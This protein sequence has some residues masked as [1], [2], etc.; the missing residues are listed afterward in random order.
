MSHTVKQTTVDLPK[1]RGQRLKKVRNM[2]NMSRLEMCEQHDFNV[3]T[4]KG[5]EIGRHGGLTENAAKMLC[6]AFATHGVICTVEWLLS[7]TGAAPQLIA[8]FNSKVPPK[9]KESL[10]IEN[11]LNFLRQ[12]YTGIVDTQLNDNAM[13]PFYAKGDFVAGVEQSNKFEKLDKQ[14]VIVKLANDKT[15][16]RELRKCTKHKT[17]CLFASNSKTKDLHQPEIVSIAHIIWHRCPL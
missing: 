1:Q 17:L 16:V 15:V 2:T 3:N 13:M 14:R 4:L 12:S 5:W 11:E 10:Q 7:N 9:Q 6:E 8:E